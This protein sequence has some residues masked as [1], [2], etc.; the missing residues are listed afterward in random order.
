M[1][2]FPRFGRRRGTCVVEAS[3]IYPVTFLLLLAIVIGSMGIFRYQEVSHL[4]REGARYASTHGAQFRKDTGLPRGT[5]TDW[6]NDIVTNAID[7]NMVS[8]DP[9]ML[10]V[11]VSWPDVA[12][13]PGTPDDRPGSKVTVT[14]SY[15]WM[16]EM[17]VAGPINLSSTSTMPITN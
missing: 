3:I 5:T 13:M 10:T 4:A 11:K 2:L 6:Q 16:P 15:L 14:V 1:I 7:P 8:M 9:S 17:F 12:T